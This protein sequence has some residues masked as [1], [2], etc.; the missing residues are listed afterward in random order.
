VSTLRELV[1]L[2]HL[3]IERPDDFSLRRVFADSLI[4]R[5]NPRGEFIR[6]QND[7]AD[8]GSTSPLR[9]RLTTHEGQLLRKHQTAWFTPL[10]RERFRQTVQFTRG[11]A[12][13]WSCHAHHFLAH[14]RWVVSH[15]PLRAVAVRSA[16]AEAIARLGATP[17]FTSLP[18][19]K[20]TINGPPWPAVA[21]LSFTRLQRLVLDGFAVNPGPGFEQL[22]ERPWFRALD[23]LD[24]NFRLDD[25]DVSALEQSGVL[26]RVKQLGLRAGALRVACPE[27]TQLKLSVWLADRFPLA[28]VLALAP[29][30]STLTLAS[31]STRAIPDGALGGLPSHLKTLRL[32][33]AQLSE[34]NVDALVDNRELDHLQLWDCRLSEVSY[35]RLR[36]RWDDRGWRCS[37]LDTRQRLPRS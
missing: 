1:E 19:V 5:G 8:L 33:F 34:A 9:T 29:K 3:I 13:R 14:G 4:E 17:A 12:E 16:D 36:L 24:L 18:E 11:F 25:D 26:A 7:L 10:R 31:L 32:E 35:D 28:P 37:D 23:A 20:L 6:V 27:L 21:G 22:C 15:H 30:L 2:R